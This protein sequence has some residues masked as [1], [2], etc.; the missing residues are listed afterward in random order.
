MVFLVR[1]NFCVYSKIRRELILIAKFQ[2]ILLFIV[3]VMTIHSIFF[4]NL[5]LIKGILGIVFLGTCILIDK[6]GY[7][8]KV[9]TAIFYIS[10]ILIVSG[11]MIE[12]LAR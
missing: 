4:K 6:I 7:R 10:S 1:I 11:F 5:Y 3:S 9:I 8:N 2:Y 12:K